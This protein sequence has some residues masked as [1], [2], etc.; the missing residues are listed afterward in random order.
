MQGHDYIF[1]LQDKNFNFWKVENN[2]VSIDSR[3][4]FLD[5]SPDGWDDI[6]IQNIRNKKYWGIDRTVSV[7]LSCVK[8]GA[9]I[10]KYVVHTRGTEE[11]L[12]LVIGSQRLAF[13]SAVLGGINFTSGQALLNTTQ[14]A[15]GTI[16]GNPGDVVNI[17]ITLTTSNSSD[18]VVGFFGA[19]QFNFNAPTYTNTYQ[20]MIPSGGSV[21]FN[22]FFTQIIGSTG[23]AFIELVNSS[24]NN[25][26]GYGYW[27]KQIL[28]TEIDLTSLIHAGVKVSCPVL[29]SGLPKYLK[30]NENTVYEIPMN[31]VDAIDVKMDGVKML[32]G[33]DYLVSNGAGFG[34][35][36]YRNHFVDIQTFGQGEVGFGNS[37]KNVIRSQFLGLN[38]DLPGNLNWF[39][40][41]TT[42][43]RLNLEWNFKVGATVAPG[44]TLVPGT[45]EIHFQVVRNNQYLTGSDI[46]V[47]SG[48][49]P[50]VGQI[51][52]GSGFI[53]LQQGDY[54]YF[55][56]FYTAIG[57]SGDGIIEYIYYDINDS[58]VKANAYYKH[59][60][61][62]IKA[63][64]LQYLYNQLIK[65][66]TESQFT[67]ALS[68][69][70][71]LYNDRVITCGNAVRGLTDAKMKISLTDLWSFLDSHSS[72]GMM[73]K[74]Q[75]VLLEEKQDLID[76]NNVIQLSSPVVRTFKQ[77]FAKE[78]FYNE[79]EIGYPELKNDVG[80]LNGNNDFNT[81][82]LFSLGTTK[83]PLK[84][85][86]VSKI[87]ASPYE[88]EGVRIK[89]FEKETT[90]NKAD[91][92][93]FVLH[94]ED[95]ITP[96]GVGE[97]AH[98]R[99]DR[100]L[101]PTA[102]GILESETIFNLELTPKRNILRNGA[103]LRSSIYK[104]DGKILAFKSA[105]K[106]AD[107]VCGGVTEKADVALS[108]LSG[109]FFE[110]VV[111]EG[112][113]QAPD[114]IIQLLDTNPLQVFQFP[115][116]GAL[117]NGIMIRSSIA[118]ATKKTQTF[119][120]L[121]LPSNDLTKLIDYNG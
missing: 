62:Y 52:N 11:P 17:K 37:F 12:F 6:S 30:A 3:P 19:F 10:I 89:T 58:Y 39:F 14:L 100:A 26:G 66:V 60:A 79:L 46:V 77:S 47:F 49:L 120:F 80:I 36:N 73:Q 25:S 93:L 83:S 111:L 97:I 44:Q 108:D 85:D 33:K 104:G 99:L 34:N 82:F 69:H 65:M 107:L 53:D 102:T 27:Y 21:P 32:I 29:E 109:K 116:A 35:E 115:I 20:V 67:A 94:I 28:R 92:D 117:Y 103:F 9:K 57:S 40:L 101:N 38:S 121:S 78:Y 50:S 13:D 119:Q 16:T 110:P 56:T 45:T 113:F 98:Y 91:N 118:P 4:Y 95:N 42:D 90:D 43:T 88:I 31:V 68:N 84:L 2:V 7:P 71:S 15:A 8:D 22:V 61:S 87:K 55:R 96:S 1:C 48:L 64:R 74:G 51:I 76:E 72:V 114:D 24:G 41:A 63:F 75:E 23:T 5:Y 112:E 59:P 105:D 81:K 86:K 18:N 54:V 106:N 70:L